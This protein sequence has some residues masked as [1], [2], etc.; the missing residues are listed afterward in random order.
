MGSISRRDLWSSVFQG[1]I[2]RSKVSGSLDEYTI[3]LTRLQV[4]HLLRRAS[5][6]VTHDLINR[7]EGKRAG[8]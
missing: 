4:Q 1:T 8:R 5:F 6:N 2:H 3:P 7:Y